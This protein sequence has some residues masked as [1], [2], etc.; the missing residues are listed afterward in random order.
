MHGHYPFRGEQL[1]GKEI[2]S[3]NRGGETVKMADTEPRFSHCQ[4]LYGEGRHRRF[5]G[6]SV[7]PGEAW[8]RL[9]WERVYIPEALRKKTV[10]KLDKSLAKQE[11]K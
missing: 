4:W 1:M 6:N 8:C 11:A 3:L 7:R 2:K 5:C 10:E 9:H